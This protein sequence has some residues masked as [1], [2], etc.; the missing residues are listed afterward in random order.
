MREWNHPASGAVA[1][2]K[3]FDAPAIGDVEKNYSAVLRHIL[4]VGKVDSS[5]AMCCLP[6]GL[7]PKSSKSELNHC[8]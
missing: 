2:G 7:H 6:V 4:D 1:T 8:Y 3:P 5:L